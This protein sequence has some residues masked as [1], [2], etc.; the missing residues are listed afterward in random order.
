MPAEPTSY[1][2]A[3][4]YELSASGQKLDS[5]EELGLPHS[6]HDNED[7]SGIP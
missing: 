3:A 6:G 5:L 4:A 1:L 2:F 7:D